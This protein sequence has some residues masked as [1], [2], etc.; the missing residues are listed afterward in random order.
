MASSTSHITSKNGFSALGLLLVILVVALTAGGVYFYFKRSN[1]DQV[2]KRDEVIRSTSTSNKGIDES[3]PSANLS[4]PASEYCIKV[5]GE[6]ASKT[7]GD[8]GAYNVCNFPD[9]QSCEEWAL[10]KRQC[11]LGGVKTIGYNTPE[12]IYCAQAGGKTKAA[13]NSNC[14]LPNGHTCSNSDF[15]NGKCQ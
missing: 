15:Y 6:L 12:E 8:G 14:S 13:P 1:L 11:P 2:L 5:G 4:N 7:R 10:Y 9:N 3:G